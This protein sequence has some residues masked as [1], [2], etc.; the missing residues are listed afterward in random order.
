MITN[1]IGLIESSILQNTQKKHCR[2]KM[3]NN[4]S[5]S[6]C[7][8]YNFWKIVLW[9]LFLWLN[10]NCSWYFFFL[11]IY[12]FMKDLFCFKF[13]ESKAIRLSLQDKQKWTFFSTTF[14]QH[15]LKLV[16]K[17]LQVH[18]EQISLLKFS[19]LNIQSLKNTVDMTLF[20]NLNLK[21]S[22]LI[23]RKIYFSKFWFSHCAHCADVC[24]WVKYQYIYGNCNL[25]FWFGIKVISSL[26]FR[27]A[28]RHSYPIILSFLIYFLSKFCYY[29]DKL[30][31]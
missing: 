24:C 19:K 2:N 10:S 6:V 28:T 1:V 13:V 18:S 11:Q 8:I 14:L 5:K 7:R 25:C 21:S 4:Q 9:L 15:L 31:Y 16:S 29:L 22:K 17:D 26:Y 12:V 30:Q 20:E 23:S 27:L 3:E